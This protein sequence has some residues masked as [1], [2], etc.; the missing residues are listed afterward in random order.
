[1][2]TTFGL[3]ACIH[4]DLVVGRDELGEIFFSHTGYV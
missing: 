4:Q 3:N 2:S 1:M